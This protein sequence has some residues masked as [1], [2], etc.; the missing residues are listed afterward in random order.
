MAVEDE[1]RI[2][3]LGTSLTAL[4]DWPARVGRR[5][6]ACPGGPVR[7]TTLARPGASVA[8][9]R[10][11]VA[12]VLASDPDILLVEFTINDADLRD[13]LG[14]ARSRALHLDLVGALRHARPDL[15]IALMTMSPASGPR[16]WLRPRL[17][18]R[19]REY[20]L[21]AQEAG[22]GLI[23]LYPRWMALPRSGRGL[24]GDGLH[25]EEAVAAALIVP[26]VA[27]YLAVAVGAECDGAARR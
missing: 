7:V 17:G 1:L 22:L 25:P 15:A 4:Y 9:G 10:E 14:V 19:Y 20:R 24:G 12:A 27:D 5:L 8:W 2:T 13:G 18:T 6:E 26:V 16:G 23:D 21:L 11:Q 3:V